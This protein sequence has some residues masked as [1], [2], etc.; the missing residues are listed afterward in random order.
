MRRAVGVL[1][2]LVGLLAIVGGSATALLLGPDGRGTTGPHPVDTD[3]VALVTA[4]G[5]LSWSG[6][7]IS[8]D[9]SVPGDRP[10]FVGL[11]N[12]VDVE[13]YLGETRRTEVTSYAVPWDLATAD[14]PGDDFLPAAPTA[15]DW[16]LAGSSGQGGAQMS[17]LLPDQTVSLAVLAVGDQ[18]L[19]GVAV[20]AS[21][22]Q[23]GGFGIGLGT[24]GLG[25]GVGILGWTVFASRPFRRQDLD[26]EG[27]ESAASEPEQPVPPRRRGEG[28]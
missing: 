8:V 10:V 21:Y 16:W 19:E 7:T 14:A 28:T 5:V 4:P 6:A 24:L 12:T 27:R 9:V 13:D 15:V 25:I 1:L 3:A 18:T 22:D 20:T 11:G 2:L 17:V 26:D 23:A